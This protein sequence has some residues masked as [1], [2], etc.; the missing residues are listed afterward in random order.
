MTHSAF[1]G[2]IPT[3]NTDVKNSLVQILLYYQVQFTLVVDKEAKKRTYREI[4]E[5]TLKYV[6]AG[7]SSHYIPQEQRVEYL[8]RWGILLDT[9]TPLGSPNPTKQLRNTQDLRQDKK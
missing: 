9:T 6:E 7:C 1:A 8:E 3:K 2:L 5:K 4:K